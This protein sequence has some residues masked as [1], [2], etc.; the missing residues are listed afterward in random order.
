MKTNLPGGTV[1]TLS[2]DVNTMLQKDEQART[3][4]LQATPLARNEWICL[5]ESAKLPETKVR[6]LERARSQLSMGQ[7]RPCCWQGCPH[8]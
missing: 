8:R 3:T 7:R 1:H 4:W 2:K 5:V 6:R